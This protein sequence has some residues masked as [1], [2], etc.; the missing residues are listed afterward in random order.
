MRFIDPL[1]R[2]PKAIARY[3]I[4]VTSQNSLMPPVRLGLTGYQLQYIT[5]YVGNILTWNAAQNQLGFNLLKMYSTG[6]I[7]SLSAFQISLGVGYEYFWS[8]VLVFCNH[9]D[10]IAEVSDLK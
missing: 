1:H 7:C 4:A 9:D 2:Q 8:G 5:K 6:M 3:V 10:A